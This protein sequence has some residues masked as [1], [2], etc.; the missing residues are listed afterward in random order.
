ML[1]NLC[2]EQQ[3]DRSREQRRAGRHPE[4][5]HGVRGEEQSSHHHENHVERGEHSDGDQVAGGEP[6]RVC[7]SDGG[8]HHPSFRIR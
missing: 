7:I 5:E 1:G 6:P 2:N 8:L 4:R 3:V